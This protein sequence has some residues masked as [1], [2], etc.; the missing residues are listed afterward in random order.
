MLAMDV[1]RWSAP[2]LGEPAFDHA[3]Q[4]FDSLP[5]SSARG[6]R[7]DPPRASPSSAAVVWTVTSPPVDTAG[8]VARGGGGIRPA[9]RLL[10]RNAQVVDDAGDAG[11]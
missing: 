1:L 11:C 10:A 9:V 6:T 5:F 2:P 4:A 7:R 3:H 8:G